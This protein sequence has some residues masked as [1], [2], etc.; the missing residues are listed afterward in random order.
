MKRP[1]SYSTYFFGNKKAVLRYITTLI[2]TVSILAVTKIIISNASEEL[3]QNV[4]GNNYFI[5][6]YTS[7]EISMDIINRLKNLE[8]V[9]SIIPTKSIKADYVAFAA[10]PDFKI[11]HMSQDNIIKMLTT[12]KI[13]YELENIYN[14]NENEAL[15]GERIRKNKNLLK[16]DKIIKGSKLKYKDS[17]NTNLLIGFTPKEFRDGSNEYIFIPKQGQ[18]DE[19][20]KKIKDIVPSNYKFEGV[21]LT[22]RELSNKNAQDTFNIVKIILTI[23]CAITTGVSSYLHYFNRKG[24]I[25]ILKALGYSDKNII[26][27]I[28]KEIIISTVIALIISIILMNFTVYLMNL[29]LAEPKGYLSFA[30]NISMISEIFIVVLSIVLFSLIPIWVLL[31]SVDK[32][33]LIEGRF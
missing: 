3:N 14:L 18:M 30:F 13:P 7:D 11:Y 5:E 6:I 17:I 9:E 32:I 27:R 12:L 10:V 2:I 4:E 25:G 16:E 20:V 26:A 21:D 15:I 28:T 23:A 29:F 1:L 33:S 8:E 31:K 24:E 19:M 22:V